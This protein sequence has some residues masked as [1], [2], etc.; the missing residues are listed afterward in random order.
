MGFRVSVN[1][2][3]Y[4]PMQWHSFL[5][6]RKKEVSGHLEKLIVTGLGLVFWQRLI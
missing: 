6:L 5:F 2:R 4:L 1:R 3:S